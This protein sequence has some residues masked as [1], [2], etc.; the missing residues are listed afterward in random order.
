MGLRF[1]VGLV[2]IFFGL[3]PSHN[4]VLLGL[5][6]L[7]FQPGRFL[8]SRLILLLLI[9]PTVSQMNYSMLVLMT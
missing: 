8:I 2:L 9:L 6:V 7:L 5:D 3:Y 1:S 4:V